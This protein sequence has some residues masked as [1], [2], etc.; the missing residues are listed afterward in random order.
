MAVKEQLRQQDKATQQ[1]LHGKAYGALEQVA[2]PHRLP[3]PN[4]LRLS[5]ARCGAEKTQRRKDDAEHWPSNRPT[6]IFEERA[7]ISDD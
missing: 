4:Q 7:V 3:C 6:A 5:P 2:Q 1:A